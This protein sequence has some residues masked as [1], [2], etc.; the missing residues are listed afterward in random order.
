MSASTTSLQDVVL[1]ETPD[2]TTTTT[3]EQFIVQLIDLLE[4]DGGSC[5]AR[6]I[7][8]DL[9]AKGRQR[10]EHYHDD[11]ITD[12]Y[13][14]LMK[15]DHS[16]LLTLLGKAIRHEWTTKEPVW[17]DSFLNE[18][19]S[20]LPELYER[21]LRLVAERGCAYLRE[22]VPLALAIQFQY[23]LSEDKDF[24]TDGRFDQIWQKATERGRKGCLDVH[25]LERDDEPLLL[26]L[27]EFYRDQVVK[28]LKL[29]GVSDTK[30]T[31]FDLAVD[32]VAL[33]GWDGLIEHDIL[34]RGC[35]R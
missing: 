23:Q 1:N 20:K 2:L 33:N 12:T 4:L 34:E 26:A 13:D 10:L 6:N 18:Q 24:Q 3:S 30:Q 21:I 15:N 29:A 28:R 27:K 32:L 17:L 11:I 7:A 16:E 19:Q 25:P 14:T 22:C 35:G 9:I 5:D 8:L 31:V